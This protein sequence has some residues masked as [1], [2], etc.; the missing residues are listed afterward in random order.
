LDVI[1]NA[2]VAIRHV[3]DNSVSALDER[4]QQRT[5]VS[6][7]GGDFI[8]GRWNEADLINKRENRF[9]VERSK[10]GG[11]CEVAEARFG[12]GR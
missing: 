12:V 5:Q 6:A 11:Y 2:A 8:A 9:A 3:T 4:I 7:R 10:A 1:P